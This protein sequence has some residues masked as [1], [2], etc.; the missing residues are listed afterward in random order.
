MRVDLN[1]LRGMGQN[2]GPPP[3]T[4]PPPPPPPSPMY[5]PP[6]WTEPRTIVIRET[7]EPRIVASS[8]EWYEDLKAG[9]ICQAPAMWL[10]V[11]G[12]GVGA[13]VLF[14]VLRK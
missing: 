3:Q 5:W 9:G 14:G 6:M 8:C 12:L 11:S 1:R 10:I 7:A 2:G 13:L 4:P